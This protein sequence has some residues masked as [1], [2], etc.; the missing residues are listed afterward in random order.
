MAIIDI[1]L[2]LLRKV[3]L[4]VVLYQ[5]CVSARVAALHAIEAFPL[6]D[7]LLIGYCNGSGKAITV[8]IHNT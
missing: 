3:G 1:G 4:F 2:R 6:A 7:N 5:V 8:C